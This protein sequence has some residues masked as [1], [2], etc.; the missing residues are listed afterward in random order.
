MGDKPA[1]C[2]ALDIRERLRLGLLSGPSAM[3]TSNAAAEALRCKVDVGAGGGGGAAICLKLGSLRRGLHRWVGLKLGSL[4]RGLHRRVGLPSEAEAET[5]AKLA[6]RENAR[7]VGEC[8][9]P[10]RSGEPAAP[11]SAS[12]TPAAADGGGSVGGSSVGGGSVGGAG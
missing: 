4:R 1:S 9:A 5:S 11:T 3:L 12:K 2:E 8:G 6:A 7:R 10:R